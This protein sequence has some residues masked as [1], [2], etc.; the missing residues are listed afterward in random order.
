MKSPHIRI[1]SLLKYL[2]VGVITTL[3]Y[4]TTTVVLIKVFNWRP[5]TSSVIGYGMSFVF[6]FL[7]N[8][9]FVFGSSMH[10]LKTA[11]RFAIISGVGFC[12]TTLIISIT[13]MIGISYYYAIMITITIM[14]LLNYTLNM[15]WTWHSTKGENENIR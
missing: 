8:H 11:A 2:V 9:Y 5:I 1:N 15:R 3:I 4:A 10:L 12:L 14:P 7:S 13:E 6:S